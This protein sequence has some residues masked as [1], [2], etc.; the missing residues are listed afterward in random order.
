MNLSKQVSELDALQNDKLACYKLFTLIIIPS[1][2]NN[3][4][5]LEIEEHLIGK[6]YFQ[7]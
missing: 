2:R 4:V 7:S 5:K 1:L 3:E 6:H